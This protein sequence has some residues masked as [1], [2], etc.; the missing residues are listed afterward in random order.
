M[1][2]HSTTQYSVFG[3]YSGFPLVAP[4]NAVLFSGKRPS[5]FFSQ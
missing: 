2:F 1:M 3:G 4:F 5:G